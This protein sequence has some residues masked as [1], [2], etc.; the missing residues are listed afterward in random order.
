MLRVVATHILGAAEIEA[1]R[2]EFGRS[3][4]GGSL[5]VSDA[6]RLVATAL[7]YSANVCPAFKV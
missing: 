5:C 1:N 3:D 2:S 4:A 6:A 7:S